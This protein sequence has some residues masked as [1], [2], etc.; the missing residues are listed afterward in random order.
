LSAECKAEV[1]RIR[2]RKSKARKDSEGIEQNPKQK[3]PEKPLP[4]QYERRANLAVA[5]EEEG[6]EAQDGMEVEEPGSEDDTDDDALFYSY[7]TKVKIVPEEDTRGNL[8][9]NRETVVPPIED[10]LAE[11]SVSDDTDTSVTIRAHLEWSEKFQNNQ[12]VF[13]CSDGGADACVIGKNAHIIG[14]SGR[15][16]NLLAY[17]LTHP[18]KRVPI[19]DAYVKVLAQNGIPVFLRINDGPIVP[20]NPVT[21]ISEYQVRDHGFIVDSVSK[22]HKL[23]PT[24][25][26]TQRLVL[27][28]VLYVPFENRGGIM[29]MSLLPISDDDYLEDGEPRFDVFEITAP[30]PWRPFRHK[31]DNHRKDDPSLLPCVVGENTI[32]LASSTGEYRGEPTPE[33][34]L[35]RGTKFESDRSRQSFG[36]VDE[37]QIGNAKGLCEQV[38]NREVQIGNAKGLCEKV[39][40]RKS[41]DDNPTG[42]SEGGNKKFSV[43]TDLLL[44]SMTYEEMIGKH[45]FQPTHISGYEGN[46]VTYDPIRD[47]SPEELQLL[48]FAADGMCPD[49]LAFATRSWHRTLFHE[50]DPQKVQPFLAWR[51]LDIV[52]KTLEVTT[53][54]AQATVSYPLRRHLKPRNPW[55]N[56]KRLNEVVSTDPIFA[57]CPSYHSNYIGAQIYY[58]LESRMI[59]VYGF[60]EEKDFPA[61]LEDFIREEGAMQALRRDNAKVEQSRVVTDI[62]RKYMI[63]DGFS[64]AHH[65][66]QNPVESGAIRWLKQASHTLM[67]RHG[68]PDPAWYFAIKYLADVHNICY[69][70]AHKSTPFQKRHGETPDISAYLQFSFWEPVLYADVDKSFPSTSERPA[71][72]IGVAHNVG[73][74]L[75]YWLFDDQTKKVIARST[76]RPFNRNK[77]IQ[78]DPQFATAPIRSTASHGGE[79]MPSREERERLIQT[80]M[81]QYDAEEPDL[82]DVI[83]HRLPNHRPP[84]SCF[85]WKPSVDG[86]TSNIAPATEDFHVRPDA[87]EYGGASKLRYSYRRLPFD[88]TIHHPKKERKRSTST[89]EKW[90]KQQYAPPEIVEEVPVPAARASGSTEKQ[91]APVS[92]RGEHRRPKNNSTN[93]STKDL[94]SGQLWSAAVEEQLAAAAARAAAKNRGTRDVFDG[95]SPT[96]TTIPSSRGVG[97]LRRSTRSRQQTRGHRA[98]RLASTAVTVTALATT[99]TTLIVPRE[100]F[101]PP[102]ISATTANQGFYMFDGTIPPLQTTPEVE[103]MRAYHAYV[104]MLND[105]Y[106]ED[107][108]N[109][110]WRVESIID[111]QVRRIYRG[112]D[113]RPPKVKLKVRYADGQKKAWLDLDVLRL[114]QPHLCINY[115]AH[116]G[117]LDK[118]GWEWTTQYFQSKS[119]FTSAVHAYKIS[120]DGTTKKYKFG[121]EVPRNVKDALRIDK[122]QGTDG[123]QKAIDLELSQILG[124]ETFKPLSEGD[125][126][127]VGYKRIPYHIVFDVKFDGRLKARLVAG[128]HRSPDV[129]REEVFSSVVSMEAVRIGFV[130]ARLNGLTVCA[131]DIGNAFLY[132]DTREKV[133]VVAGPEF[134]PE[135]EGKRML[136]VKSCY[137]LKSSSAR[138]HE[139]LSHRVRKMG[140]CPS[141]ADPDLWMKRFEDGHYEYIARYVDDVIA[142]SRDPMPIMLELQKEYIMKGVGKPQYYLGG[143]V[144][145]LDPAWN[146]QGIYTAFSAE[147]YIK[148]CVPRMETMMERTFKSRLVPMDPNYHPELDDS[149][150]CTPEEISKYRSLIGSANWIITLGR[151]DIAFAVSTYARYQMAPRRGHL[152]GMMHVFGYLK[153]HMKGRLVID[154]NPNPPIRGR[155]KLSDGYSWV[156]FYPDAKEELPYDMPQPDGQEVTLTCYVDADHARDKVTCRS[157]TGIVLLLNNTPILWV[158]RRQKTVETSTY[159]SEMV[160]ARVAVDCMVEFRYKLRMLGIPVEERSYIVGDNMSV[161]VNTTLPSSQLKKKHQA[162]NYHRV[163]EAIAAGYVVFG[164]VDS[165]DNIA[166]VCT[167]PLNGTLFHRLMDQY[168]FRQPEAL[169]KARGKIPTE[170]HESRGVIEENGAS[171]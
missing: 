121:V 166:D 114:H 115:A 2:R 30:G 27:N 31:N 79:I 162:C 54:L 20:D 86:T 138:F 22:Y 53:Q 132:G 29:G 163:R 64:E 155:A 36:P 37:V 74:S 164:H 59:N 140:Y 77:R 56:V 141:K 9:S 11:F 112:L 98:F 65:Q 133:Y 66:W 4:P 131:G 156:E 108:E 8:S 116:N 92:A 97:E 127:P 126:I 109:E 124:Y 91:L 107:P 10:S 5:M 62:Q 101:D 85:K 47:C 157:V 137:G 99:S 43:G 144:E 150:L 128:G 161:V 34:D 39:E 148:N 55:M 106:E 13:C 33:M 24:S 129:P 69:C 51:P 17:D 169:M 40:N 168:M 120:T 12:E 110:R 42:L 14:Y 152:D 103:E 19:G 15:H 73:D 23:S 153:K 68:V 89:K 125:R 71:R 49:S 6:Q 44:D 45:K 63:K 158:S 32:L 145:E 160:A 83:A 38:E 159:G 95:R 58:G 119:L 7:M 60:K 21:L 50:L 143:D 113:H 111:H 3:P 90:Y 130:L 75:T 123:W 67:D 117:L 81:D 57:N 105:V 72:W 170:S 84:T 134:G 171:S 28:D 100:F 147:T 136:F 61:T 48:A 76:V 78:W 1:D 154:T 82:P 151:F 165:E 16:A 70:A 52:R 80:S 96:T 94:D 135:L 167:K 93:D 88:M 104:D 122:E 149:P 139:H 146:I 26:G 25:Y 142:F 46:N 87:D 102:C 118:P 41:F 35:T 18:S